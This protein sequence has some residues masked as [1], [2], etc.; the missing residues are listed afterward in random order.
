[1]GTD[2][3]Q[4]IKLVNN[5]QMTKSVLCIY[6]AVFVSLVTLFSNCSDEVE[7]PAPQ[8]LAIN[9]EKGVIGE[10]I[11]ITGSNFETQSDQNT[12]T[13]NGIKASVTSATSS[14]LTVIAP[15]STTGPITVKTS[16]GEATGSVFTYLSTDKAITKFSV[17][18]YTTTIVGNTIK[19][20]VP[21]FTENKV[22]S[23]DITVSPQAT[24]TP[25]SG[26]L[27]D[28]ANAVSYT[29]VAEDHS[30]TI[31][32]VSLNYI[33]GLKSI[34]FNSATKYYDGVID[35]INMKIKV[36]VPYSIVKTNQDN[37]I[38]FKIGQA[39]LESGYSLNPEIGV[40]INVDAPGK[41][42]VIAPNTVQQQYSLEVVSNEN[43]ITTFWLS[44]QYTGF[45]LGALPY[46]T[47]PEYSEGLSKD[48]FVVIMLN[49]DNVS[50]VVPY[51]IKFSPKA[52]ISPAIT[53]PINLN[54]DVVYTVTAENGD[55]RLWTIRALKRPII[56][57]N[58]TPHASEIKPAN[59]DPIWLVIRTVSQVVYAELVNQ[60]TGAITKS[61]NVSTIL[62]DTHTYIYIYP[63][64][65]MDKGNYTFNV[66]LA[67]GTIVKSKKVLR[68]E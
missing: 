52:T 48:S 4:V 43:E 39:S 51:M 10:T 27:V 14:M 6:I 49:T 24:I 47:Q 16:G 17:D 57:T 40:G 62:S 67:D 2:R 3:R 33:Y 58:D 20:D 59:G 60:T 46:Q 26:E 35:H 23:P 7:K 5:N 32:K 31:Y 65:A 42:N 12:V 34:R 45:G 41:V 38:S 36:A 64:S 63:E 54:T 8:V 13:F 11:T 9:P 25:A 53:K 37:N 29:V 61:T 68:L 66:T 56:F 30:E 22:F 55:V 21:A 44:N 1:M 15:T 50:S 28:F 18:G 19:I